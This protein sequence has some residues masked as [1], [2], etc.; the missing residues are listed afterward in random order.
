MRSVV[1]TKALQ[2][3][4]VFRRRECPGCPAFLSAHLRPLLGAQGGDNER[5]QQSPILMQGG[6]LAK[7]G[8]F[9]GMML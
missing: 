3:G 9:Q 4:P 1:G 5:E 6:R 2:A 8:Q 7:E